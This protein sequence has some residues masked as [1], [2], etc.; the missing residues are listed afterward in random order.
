MLKGLVVC[1][2]SGGLRFPL[3]PSIACGNSKWF[4]TLKQ[5]SKDVV[6]FAEHDALTQPD[7]KL[8]FAD[9]YHSANRY[10]ISGE[11]AIP[12][13]LP[14]SQMYDLK[15]QR[16]LLGRARFFRGSMTEP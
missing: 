3:Q 15:R 9:I 4:A 7:R 8:R 11:D 1:F 10:A 2:I 12:I 5:R 13:L 6:T 16:L 14:S